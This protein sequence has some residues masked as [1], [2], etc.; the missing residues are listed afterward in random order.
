MQTYPLGPIGAYFA[1]PNG[2][3]CFQLV[4][5]S[6][7]GCKSLRTV[8]RGGGHYHGDVADGQAT[9]AVCDR[10]LEIVIVISNGF[11]DVFEYVVGHVDVGF[12]YQVVNRAPLGCDCEQR[13]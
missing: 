6:L 10:D 7:A 3:T 4:D 1:F 2:G 8:G 12:V 5:A 13:H 11:A 9:Y